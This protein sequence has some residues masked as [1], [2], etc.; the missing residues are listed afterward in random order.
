MRLWQFLPNEQLYFGTVISRPEGKINILVR[1]QAGDDD[2]LQAHCSHDKAAHGLRLTPIHDRIKEAHT[3][4]A[5]IQVAMQDGAGSNKKL[6]D[7]ESEDRIT[8]RELVLDGRDFSRR[9]YNPVSQKSDWDSEVT[10]TD[11]AQTFI[12]EVLGKMGLV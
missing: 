2:L 10:P 5:F 11:I 7:Y 8:L 6:D 3:F 9:R 4:D 1:L 12:T